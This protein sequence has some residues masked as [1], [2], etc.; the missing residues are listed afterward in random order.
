[1]TNTLP[2]ILIAEDD[3]DDREL[4]QEAFV[5]YLPSYRLEFYGD[6]D[7]LLVYVN[8]LV[9]D[10]LPKLIILDLNMPRMGGIETLRELKLNAEIN[11]VP[12]VIFSTSQNNEDRI[13]S[14]E[15]GANDFVSKP[16][17]YSG[18]V[19]AIRHIMTTWV[20]PE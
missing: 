16:I 4:I 10:L 7:D 9:A 20:K 2:Y 15:L 13:K 19:E 3:L 1:M 14:L 11:K 6:G 8:S 5:H 12:V 17:T 18:L